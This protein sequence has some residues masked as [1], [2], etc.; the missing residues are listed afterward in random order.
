MNVKWTIDAA[1]WSETIIA[2]ITSSPIEICT[3][4]IENVYEKVS[5]SRNSIDFG[6]VII[7]SH[8]KMKEEK[9]HFVCYTPL[10]LANAGFHKEAKNI[11]DLL[12]NALN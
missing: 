1:H 7:V 4:A 12:D 3:R 5:K 10:A 2:P 8:S 9:E 11:Q 6:L